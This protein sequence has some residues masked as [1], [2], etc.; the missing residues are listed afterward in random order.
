MKSTI[1]KRSIDVSGRRTSISLEKPFWESLKEIA[2]ARGKSQPQMVAEM[3]EDMAGNL[4]ST[5]RLYVLRY[6]RQQSRRRPK[7]S[8]PYSVGRVGRATRPSYIASRAGRRCHSAM[9]THSPWYDPN[10][11]K[12]RLLAVEQT[13]RFCCMS[14]EIM[15]CVKQPGS[16]ALLQV[17]KPQAIKEAIDDYAEREMGTESTPKPLKTRRRAQDC[18]RPAPSVRRRRPSER[19]DAHEIVKIHDSNHLAALDDQ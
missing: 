10:I 3:S 16:Y 14:E 17:I 8:S 12:S 13:R 19:P 18:S 4:S 9:N 2:L 6:Y 15:P 1:V 11:E 7:G 5:I